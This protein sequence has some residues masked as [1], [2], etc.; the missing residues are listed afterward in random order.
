MHK[1]FCKKQRLQTNDYGFNYFEKLKTA[2]VKSVIIFGGMVVHSGRVFAPSDVVY[3][4]LFG[5]NF[6]TV[7]V[8]FEHI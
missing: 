1:H 4:P 7:N 8:L 5:S 3:E 2:T 6:A